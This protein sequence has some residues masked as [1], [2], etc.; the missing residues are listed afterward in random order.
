MTTKA[1]PCVPPLS[2]NDK[3]LQYEQSNYYDYFRKL[4]TNHVS[5]GEFGLQVKFGGSNTFELKEFT[6]NAQINDSVQS[7]E[8]KLKYL[9]NSPSPVE[10]KYVLPLPPSTTICNMK[11]EYDG[12][13]LVGRI[14][15]KEKASEIYSDA[16]ASGGQ[17]FMAER[18]KNGYFVISLGNVPSQKDVEIT[19]E[20]VGEMGSH[21]DTLHFLLHK[22]YFPTYAFKLNINLDIN[23]TGGIESIHVD[24]LSFNHPSGPDVTYTNEKK[25]SARLSASFEQAIT[26]NILLAI[27]PQQTEKPQPI[28]ELNEKDN[29]YAMGLNFQPDFKDVN[30]FDIN[31]RSEFI[32]L[33]DCSGSMS[34]E[35]IGKA[36]KALQLI[37]RSLTEAVKFNI[38]CFGS[39]FNKL[40]PQSVVYTDATL[41]QASEYLSGVDADLGGTDI[42]NPIKDILRN[43]PY[44]PKFPKQVFVFTDGEVDDREGLIQFV[45]TENYVRIFTY[46]IGTSVDRELIIGMSRACRGYFEF[47]E[48]IQEME[49]KVMSLFSIAVEPML[50]NINIDYGALKVTQSPKLVRPIFNSERMMLYALIEK[51]SVKSKIFGSNTITISGTGPKGEDIKYKVE[52]DFANACTKSQSIHR[53]CAYSIIKDLLEADQKA[54]KTESKDTIVKLGKQYG[55]VSEHTSYI[56]TNEASEPTLETMK[57]VEVNSREVKSDEGKGGIFSGITKIFSKSPKPTST[58]T[59]GGSYPSVSQ[60]SPFTTSSISFQQGPQPTYQSQTTSSPVLSSLS[61]GMALKKR[62]QSPVTATISPQIDFDDMCIQECEKMESDFEQCEV[63]TSYL[64]PPPPPIPVQSNRVYSSPVPPPPSIP[65]Q[66]HNV[67]PS[68]SGSGSLKRNVTPIGSGNDLQSIVSAQKANGAFD[69]SRINFNLAKDKVP[70]GLDLDVWITLIIIAKLTKSY[71]NEKDQ[72]N[73]IAQ[74]AIKFVRAALSKINKLNDYQTFLTQA[75]AT[76]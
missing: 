44:D 12:K 22:L 3:S 24:G 68:V 16:I 37:L 65:V 61:Q 14:K 28:L 9:N 60:T 67:Y 30:E 33:L 7:A 58:V 66:S 64:S 57:Q 56:V 13:I 69:E 54:S 15:E 62:S 70:T 17:G 23:I 31:Q 50:Y 11:V 19:L 59:L 49:G 6:I 75:E 20:L 39:D 71:S 10:G 72:W 29:T 46:G 48:N 47:I 45:S 53:L 63:K 43:S 42:L 32:F 41:A 73:L 52:L 18:Q 74:K 27:K 25:S 38:V 40:F 1:L 76:I 21:M 51:D 34:G 4:G 35:P 26:K 2:F 8:F 5:S 55:I 36:K